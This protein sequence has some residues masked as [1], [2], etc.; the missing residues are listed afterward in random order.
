M[1]RRFVWGIVPVVCLLAVSLRAGA[2]NLTPFQ[3][4]SIE[5]Y[6]QLYGEILSESELALVDGFTPDEVAWLYEEALPYMRGMKK[7]SK[8]HTLSTS[9]KKKYAAQGFSTTT[10]YL[11]QA[12]EK[13]EAALTLDTDAGERF[14]DFVAAGFR[15]GGFYVGDYSLRF[16]QGLALWNGFSMNA[17]GEPSS[18]VRRGRGIAL[19]KSNEENDFFRGVAYENVFRGFGYAAFASFNALD[20]RVVDGAYTSLKETGIHVTDAEKEW[21]NAMHEFVVGMAVSR[22]AGTWQFTFLAT[23]Y[24][25]DKKNGR[26]LRKDNE[27][28]MFDG[29]WGNASLSCYG[30]I[31]SVRIS[32]EAAMDAHFAPAVT[33]GAVWSPSYN[34]EAAGSFRA[35]SPAY[36]AVHASD[37]TNNKIGGSLAVKYI[38]GG[39]KLNANA[40]S[41]FFPWYRFNK[42]AGGRTIKARAVAEYSFDSG[43]AATAQISWSERLKYRAHLSVPVGSFTFAVRAEGNGGGYACYAEASFAAKK[44]GISARGTYYDVEDWNSRIYFYEKGLPQTFGSQAYYGKGF[45]EYLVI[46]YSPNSRLDFWLKLQQDYSAFLMRIFIPG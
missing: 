1:C 33:V 38:S 28:Q 31:G 22:E 6:V 7:E 16:G 5:D 18:M 42:P 8:K 13:F 36:I 2:Q 17:L 27:L 45:G 44:L 32:G 41:D 46:K 11:Y 19:H 34:F 29:L 15:K 23:A 26:K 35:F 20:A 4:K 39:F 40:Q 43:A 10:K 3:I 30:S 14:P 12:G 25:Y 37:G 21:K 24:G 9:L